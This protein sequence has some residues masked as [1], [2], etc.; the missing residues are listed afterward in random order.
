MMRRVVETV[1]STEPDVI[2]LLGDFVSNYREMSQVRMPAGEI[3]SGLTGLK[4]RLG[5]FAVLGNHDGFYDTDLLASEFEKA[6][7]RVLQDEVSVIEQSGKKLRIFGMI[8][9]LHMG[10][11]TDF[12][13]KKQRG[14]AAVPPEGQI[15]VLQHGPDIFPAINALNTFGEPYKLMLAGHTHGGQ[16]RFPILGAP[17]VPSSF[18]QKYDR[19]HITENGKHLFVTSGIGNSILPFRFMSPP[20]ITVLTI[21]S[22]RSE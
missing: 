19:G 21:R 9:H 14:L 5:V 22:D 15:I 12:N 16:I 20:E 3:A 4:A 18:G 1:N 10:G 2:V 13:Q 6:G 7:I 8:D 17:M 11:W